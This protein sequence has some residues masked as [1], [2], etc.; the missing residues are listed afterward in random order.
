MKTALAAP[1]SAGR[2]DPLVARLLLDRIGF[3]GQQRLVDEEVARLEQAAVG[4]D[5]V[6]GREQHDVARDELARG[7]VDLLAVAQHRS[8]RATEPCSASAALS[9]RYSWTMSST[10]LISTIVAMMTKAVRSPV[11][12]EIAAASRIS[13][14]G[15]ANRPR[16][17]RSS[18]SRRCASSGLGPSGRAAP[19][20]RRS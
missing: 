6:A 1:A 15:L 13:T 17:V 11:S 16:N 8:L 10:T 9:A 7:D 14:S 18:D 20:P 5:E 19:P 3:A 2:G 4:G 12:A